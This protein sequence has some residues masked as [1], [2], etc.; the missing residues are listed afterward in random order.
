MKAESP[1]E[2]R[3]LWASPWCYRESILITAWLLVFGIT[4]EI[5]TFG[6]GINPISWPLNL[7]VLVLFITALVVTF[8]FNKNMAFVRWVSNIPNA[9]CAISFTGLLILIMAILPQVQ[10][11]W[12]ILDITG[13][14]HIKNSYPYLVSQLFLLT[15]LG[16]TILRRLSRKMTRKNIA[17]LIN[18]FGIWITLSAAYAGA[19]DIQKFSLTLNENQQFINIAYIGGES[20]KVLQLPF[21]IKLIDFDISFYDPDIGVYDKEKD[22]YLMKDFTTKIPPEKQSFFYE[23]W[24]IKYVYY[25]KSATNIDDD[26]YESNFHGAVPALYVHVRDTLDLLFKA[27][28]LTSGS[29][30]IPRKNIQLDKKT[31]LFMDDPKVQEY[32]SLVAV[33][34][35]QS[36]TDTFRIMVNSPLQYMGWKFYQA[37]YDEKKGKWSDLSVLEAIK[38]PWLPAVYAGI[39]LLLAGSVYLVWSG[40]KKPPIKEEKQ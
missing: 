30:K 27:G 6:A 28:W 39:F 3:K 19:G 7:I 23:K 15:S 22:E 33:K 2:N 24:D 40:K 20:K 26:F 10:G 1:K 9:I 4:L 5:F 13:A 32:N 34:A 29:Y 21:K 14:T 11:R 25:L 36:E 8:F 38:D 35:D 17:F 31:I 12:K 16:F 18:H 37:S